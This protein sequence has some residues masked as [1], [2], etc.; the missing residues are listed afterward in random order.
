MFKNFNFHLWANEYFYR[1]KPTQKLVSIILLPLSL[2]YAFIIILKKFFIRPKDFGIKI[3]SVGN[4]ILGGSGKTP[5]CIAIANEFQGG[6]IILRGYKRTSKGL[7]KVCENGKI[8]VDVS[9]SGDEAMEYAKCVKNANVIV[10][11]KRELAIAEAKKMG[12]RYILLDD[13][14]GKFHINKFDILIKPADEPSSNFTIPSGIYRYPKYFYKFAD[15]IA[16]QNVTH[17]RKSEILQPTNKMVLLTA[18]ANP[19]RLS[20]HFDATITQYFYP[21]HYA[22]K[23][24]E[25][26][27]ILQKHEATSLLVTQKDLVKIEN[28]EL[29]LSIITLKTTLS[30][31]FKALLSQALL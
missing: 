11:E 14:F 20:Q 2:L 5:L 31:E 29:P 9:Q 23:K 27:E 30:D 26:E 18:I 7:V 8:L 17:F 24:A 12:A 22:F 19:M 25:L 4:L 6:V 15:F 3:I 13:G 21:D 1:P 10:C 16:L 28:F